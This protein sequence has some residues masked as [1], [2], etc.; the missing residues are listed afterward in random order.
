MPAVH[1]REDAELVAGLRAGDEAAFAQVVDTYGASLMRV[2]ALY[3]RDRA[4]AQEVVQETW[5]GV[6]RGIDRFEGRS[7]FKTWLFR[8]L[9]NTA[10]TRGV[11][12]ARTV[13]FA[14]LSA[15]AE[16]E[17]SVS[18]DQF[19][20]PDTAWP[21]HWATGPAPWTTPLDV[22]LT[23][24]TRELLRKAIEQLPEAQ[25]RVVALR[26][27]EGWSSDEVCTA[28]EISEANQRVLLHRGRTKL[29]AAIDLRAL[30]EVG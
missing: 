3:V 24:E 18:A 11:R 27:V 26:D 29:R 19:L 8:I 15:D 23:G 7:S 30:E 16:D 12:E 20:G 5:L 2:A 1:Y 21:G 9:T 22:L 14:A 17:P 28:L 10:K 4:V 6:L 13:P 25:R